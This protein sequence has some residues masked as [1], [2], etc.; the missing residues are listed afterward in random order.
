MAEAMS[1]GI[2][3]TAALSEG[4]DAA[5]FVSHYLSREH[6]DGPRDRLHDGCT[7]GAT[8]QATTRFGPGRLRRWRVEKPPG[9]TEPAGPS[10][11]TPADAAQA[12]GRHPRRAVAC[13]VGAIVLSRAPARTD[14]P[15][16]DEILAVCAAMPSWVQQK[17]PGYAQGKGLASAR[18][19]EVHRLSRRAA[20]SRD[21]SSRQSDGKPPDRVFVPFDADA[22]T[23]RNLQLPGHHRERLLQDR[24]R[25]SPATPA[26]APSR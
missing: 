26:N 6:R 25:P 2:A 23:I 22:G 1:C 3:Q 18:Q 20:P 9:Q 24:G 19:A 11:R 7:E 17:P 5:T 4:V 15:L 16:A 13:A 12:R 21:G 14:S 10:H 8:L